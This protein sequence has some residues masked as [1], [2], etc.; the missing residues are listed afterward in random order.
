MSDEKDQIK[1]KMFME[2]ILSDD[3]GLEDIFSDNSSDDYIPSDSESESS[4]ASDSH[5]KNKRQKTSNNITSAINLP[6]TSSKNYF[7]LFT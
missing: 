1:T 7:L 4:N 3:D 6:S 5:Q 2:E